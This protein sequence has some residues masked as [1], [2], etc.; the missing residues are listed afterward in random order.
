MNFSSFSS[1]CIGEATGN[2]QVVTGCRRRAIL[3]AL[4][5]VWMKIS[6]F[7]CVKAVSTNCST[8]I[9]VLHLRSKTYKYV[10]LLCLI[11]SYKMYAYLELRTVLQP[12]LDKV[13]EFHENT[14][15]SVF[16]PVPLID[17]FV[18]PRDIEVGRGLS[19]S[20][21]ERTQC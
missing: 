20:L 4:F 19:A 18:S 11:F 10:H 21:D 12:V 15:T 16:V 13:F 8:S 6:V 17:N 5:I 14:N 2:P 7:V 9:Y 3:A 1:N